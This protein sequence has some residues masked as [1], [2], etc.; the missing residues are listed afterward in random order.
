M[1]FKQI[2]FTA[3]WLTS[4]TLFSNEPFVIGRLLGQLGNQM[5]EVATASA[6]AWDNGAE[7]YFPDLVPQSAAYQ[8]IFYAFRNQEPEGQVSVRYGTSPFG[9]SPIPYTPNMEICGYCQNEKYFLHHRDK[10]VKLFSP[11]PKDLKYIQSKYGHLLNRPNT[12][13]IH[14]RYYYAEKPDEASFIQYDH[15]YYEK[16]MSQ[17]PND[18]VFIVTSD[19]LEFAQKNIPTNGREVYFIE[20]EPFYIDFFIQSL[21]KHNIIAN[22]TFS[23]WSAWLNQN[24]EKIVVRPEI[25]LGGYPD[26][27]GPDNWIKIHAEGM[28]RA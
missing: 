17:F 24:P 12:V 1:K 16:A 2:L 13:S 15:E 3:A 20:N 23:W 27:G 21:C 26:I 18:S 22:S 9:Y 14:L 4:T 8:H 7:A 19:N 28:K 6:V 5:F 10:L 11:R 25:W